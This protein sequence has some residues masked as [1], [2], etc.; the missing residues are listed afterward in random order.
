MRP[1]SVCLFT[2]SLVPSGVGAHMLTLAYHLAREHQVALVCPSSAGGDAL[3]EAARARGIEAAPIA[4]RDAGAEGAFAAWLEQRAVDVLHVHAG[5]GWEG[6]HGVYAGP[7]A[8]VA[9]VRTEHLP[10][11]L[12]DPAQQREHRE[13]TEHCDRII[14]VSAGVRDSFAAAGVDAHRLCVVRNGIDARTPSAGPAAVRRRLPNIPRG[15]RLVVTVARF[16][17]QKGYHD[18]LQ[19]VPPVIERV[20]DAHFLWVGTGPLFQELT[21]RVRTT[22][23]G[24]HVHFPGTIADVPDLLAASEV[25]VLPSRFE[26]LP[27]VAL[28][29]MA[30][31]LP[32]VATRVCGTDEVVVDGRTGLLVEAGAPRAL[33]NALISV[34]AAPHAARE[35][36]RAGR[37]RFYDEFTA[38]RM[39]AETVG[40]YRSVLG[41]RSRDRSKQPW[42]AG[43][44][45]PAGAACNVI[46]HTA[47]MNH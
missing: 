36:G 29:A 9:T 22:G 7:L 47:R 28:E 8:R 40:V 39:A 38:A 42:Q 21:N 33:A 41:V 4:V 15:A 25:L 30:A 2:D 1:L 10:Y 31:G 37:R 24:E 14:C 35:M 27:L 16:T 32:V 17:E 3:L 5:I 18:L 6:H 13:M 44:G 19:A 45:E 43:M 46:N 23:I 12:T 26:G 11:L 34:L 20:P